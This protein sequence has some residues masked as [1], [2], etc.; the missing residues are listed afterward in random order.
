M[1]FSKEEMQ[2]LYFNMVYIRQFELRMMELFASGTMPG[3]VHL[4]LGQEACMAGVCFNLEDG[5]TIGSTHREHGVLLSMGLDG[6]K[7]LAELAG[8]KTGYC[9]GKGGHLHV[10]AP[11][12][13]ILG[14][15]AILGPGQTIIN[16]FAFA[17]KARKNG[18]VAVSMFGEGASNRGEFHEGMNLASIWKLPTVY[19]LT[20]NGYAFSNPQEKQQPITE[21]SKRAAGYDMPGV[22]VDGN[23]VLAVT[24]A[25]HEAVERAREGGGPTL[26]EL[27]TLRWRG[28][29]EGDKAAYR[30][31]EILDHWKSPE[32]EPIA[33]FE[34]VLLDRGIMTQEDF[35][36]IKAEVDA[37]IDGHIKFMEESDPT[38]E[39]E[40]YTDVYDVFEEGS[41]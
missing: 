19:V 5:D 24:E 33:R 30:S 32:K 25:V 26:V 16:G 2:K 6:D 15:N 14:N 3:G 22:T 23:D 13:G 4:G 27:K 38:P 29:S 18:R 12:R 37:K 7:I 36:R 21:L 41:V 9:K 35:D 10:S 34:K 31:K 17:N 11:G 20:D 8:K 39:E 28:H 40:I 1:E